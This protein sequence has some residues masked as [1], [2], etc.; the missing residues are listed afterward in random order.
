MPNLKGPAPK[1]N[2]DDRTL[3]AWARVIMRPKPLVWSEINPD[4]L[5]WIAEVDAHKG[6][7]DA[8][9]TV[10]CGWLIH[11]WNSKYSPSGYCV[12][13]LEQAPR[14]NN[15]QSKGHSHST[16]SAYPHKEPTTKCQFSLHWLGIVDY[17]TTEH[18]L[19]RIE[20]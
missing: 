12:L 15:M 4:E 19:V 10:V 16:C 17:C 1:T 9:Y 7:G 13:P 11:K 20:R 14:E 6:M 2:K 5:E 18:E 8:H 3:D